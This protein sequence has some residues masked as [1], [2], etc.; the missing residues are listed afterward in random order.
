MTT[1]VG[2]ERPPWRRLFGVPL[3]V[4]L[5][6]GLLMVVTAAAAG[7]PLRDPEGFL[8]P[9]YVRLP[10]LVLL[11]MAV[12]VVP[13]VLLR[14]PGMRGLVKSIVQILHERWTGP[15][16]A[17]VAA[18]LGT[19]YLAYV[20][21][22]NLKSFLPFL[23]E[24]LTDRALMATD[25]WFAFGS[26]PADVLHTLLGT[27]FTTVVLSAVYMFYMLFVPITLAAALVWS[28]DLTRGAWYVTA[29]SFNWILGTATY[30]MLP[31]LGPIYVNEQPFADLPPTAV[32][33]LQEALYENRLEVLADPHATEAVHGIAAFA[34]LHVSVVFTAALIAHLARLPKPVRWTMWGFLVLT[35]I[36]TVYFGWHY[37]VDVPAGLAVGGLSVG[38]AALAVGRKTRVR[39]D[40]L[41]R[42]RR[43]QVASPLP[44]REPALDVVRRTSPVTGEEGV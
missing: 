8:G 19:F 34:S 20:A 21:Y 30:Y 38:L 5:S 22:R 32:T 26:H 11:V 23:Q 35:S 10:L 15:R 29:L 12:D 18:G 25:S 37:V 13:R 36:A 42:T 43:S 16:L 17:I 31:S 27:G 33:D 44:A 7:L 41:V 9:S 6:F 39:S 1:E 2:R 4:T 24:R 40:V 28:N 3:I 14:R